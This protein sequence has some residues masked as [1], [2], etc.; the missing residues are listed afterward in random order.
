M[1]NDANVKMFVYTLAAVAYIARGD[2]PLSG[3]SVSQ[4]V[5]HWAL[6]M[7]PHPALST[8]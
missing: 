2:M 5:T 3:Q 6:L 8:V 7:A 1:S 4:L